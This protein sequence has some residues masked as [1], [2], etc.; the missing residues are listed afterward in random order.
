[1][2]SDD[3]Y[4]MSGDS[5]PVRDEEK[6]TATKIGKDDIYA[7][8]MKMKKEEAGEAAESSDDDDIS[9]TED[10]ESKDDVPV[11][12]KTTDKAPKTSKPDPSMSDKYSDDEMSEAM[13]VSMGN[14]KD[15][16]FTL[17]MTM[18]KKAA[19]A[20]PVKSASIKSGSASED[21]VM[22]DFVEESLNEEKD[23]LES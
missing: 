3:D 16:D 19:V 20:S 9:I 11:V 21:D 4:S 7:K 2:E 1:M 10:E 13:E 14:V 17:S 18:K 22:E 23:F 8:Y 15:E 12:T 6:K 5:A